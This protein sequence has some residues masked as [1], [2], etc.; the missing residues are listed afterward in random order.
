[1]KYP[2]YYILI[3]KIKHLSNIDS[4]FSNGNPIDKTAITNYLWFG[5]HVN[6]LFSLINVYFATYIIKINIIL[7]TGKTETPHKQIVNEWNRHVS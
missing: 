2:F 5:F 6:F 3:A 7:I 4:D 1:M